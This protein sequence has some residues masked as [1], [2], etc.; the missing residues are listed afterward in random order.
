MDEIAP[1]TRFRNYA[2]FEGSDK[3]RTPSSMLKHFIELILQPCRFPPKNI[4]HSASRALFKK[5]GVYTKTTNI[6]QIPDLSMFELWILKSSK[7]ELGAVAQ[8]RSDTMTA[9]QDVGCANG[10]RST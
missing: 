10:L 6:I 5:A 7:K 4:D 8:V 3:R 2:P 9:K 1:G